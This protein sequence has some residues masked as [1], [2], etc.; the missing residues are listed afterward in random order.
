MKARN[1]IDNIITTGAIPVLTAAG[2]INSNP[3]FRRRNGSVL[4]IIN[5]QRS[6]HNRGGTTIFY[7]NIGMAFDEI[8]INQG[9]DLN[10]PLQKTLQKLLEQECHFR[11]RLERL[12]TDCPRWWVAANR[13]DA[14]FFQEMSQTSGR[15]IAST[16]EDTTRVAAFLSECMNRVIIE[17]DRLDSPKEYLA[18]R[19]KD[20]P[21]NQTISQQLSSKQ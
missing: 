1:F 7:I 12:I 9:L 13:E 8:W 18:H 5:F 2:F 14:S 4:Q 20:V 16:V 15:E 3:N 17:L 10:G 21:G 6:L 11:S 19:W